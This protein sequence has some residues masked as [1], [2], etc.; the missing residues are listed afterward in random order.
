MLVTRPY[1]L[2]KILTTVFRFIYFFRK[3]DSQLHDVFNV[4]IA[5]EVR[6]N[7][8]MMVFEWL[9]VFKAEWYWM[10]I[11]S[12]ISMIDQGFTEITIKD[13]PSTNYEI[14]TRKLPYNQIFNLTILAENRKTQS[15]PL[16]I[17]FL[18]SPPPIDNLTIVTSHEKA[19]A[20]WI[21]EDGAEW[22]ELKF[23][24]KDNKMI[25]E[26]DVPLVEESRLTERY[27]EFDVKPVEGYVLQIRSLAYD[28]YGNV[29][30]GEWLTVQFYSEFPPLTKL[31]K[32]EDASD[33]DHVTYSWN[34]VGYDAKY[35]LQLLDLDNMA[36]VGVFET[37]Q[38]FYKI[39]GLE[40]ARKY[41][42]QVWPINENTRGDDLTEDFIT[43]LCMPHDVFSPH[44]EDSALEIEW[45]PINLAQKYSVHVKPGPSNGNQLRELKES[46]CYIETL[47]PGIQ[48]T[49]SVTAKMTRS[50]GVKVQSR[51]AKLYQYTKLLAPK[52]LCINNQLLHNSS[53]VFTWAEMGGAEYY[54]MILKECTPPPKHIL[55]PGFSMIKGQRCPKWKADNLKC[56]K[57]GVSW[58]SSSKYLMR[59]ITAGTPELGPKA[60]ILSDTNSQS[61][62][63]LLPGNIYKLWL[64]GV[65]KQT[66]SEYGVTHFVTR[67]KTTSDVTFDSLTH[68]SVHFKWQP[69][70]QAQ[71]YTIVVQTDDKK[72]KRV[73]KISVEGL[74]TTVKKLHPN[75]AYLFEVIGENKISFSWPFPVTLR[76]LL[77][78]TTILSPYDVPRGE[79]VSSD[80]FIIKW[81]QVEGAEYYIVNITGPEDF[82]KT[83]KIK[84]KTL[85]EHVYQPTGLRHNA[86]HDI[87]I[88]A[89]NK[90]TEG[91]LMTRSFYTRPSTPNNFRGISVYDDEVTVGWDPV[92][93]ITKYDIHVYDEDK[94]INHVVIEDGTQHRFREL[95]PNHLYIFVIRAYGN[96]VSDPATIKIYTKIQGVD[97]LAMNEVYDD[98]MVLD[99]KDADGALEYRVEFSYTDATGAA[100][101]MRIEYSKYS[102]CELKDLVPNSIYYIEIFGVNENTVGMPMN[103]TVITKLGYIKQLRQDIELSSDTE[104]MIKWLQVP[105]ADFFTIKVT[106]S[107]N[108]KRIQSH[109]I[110]ATEESILL[111]GLRPQT[112]YDVEIQAFS[113][114]S[115][116]YPTSF[117]AQTSKSDGGF[118]FTTTSTTTSTTLQPLTPI[119][120]S[121]FIITTTT[122]TTTTTTTSS[123]T[124]TSIIIVERL[125]PRLFPDEIV[126]SKIE[127]L[128]A[129][130]DLPDETQAAILGPVREA[131]RFA[132]ELEVDMKKTGSA[133]GVQAK[134]NK[135]AKLIDKKGF[136]LVEYNVLMEVFDSLSMRPHGKTLL[137]SAFI[138]GNLK[139]VE[140]QDAAV[141]LN[142]YKDKYDLSDQSVLAIK[143]AMTM[144]LPASYHSKMS[145]LI[146]DS[147]GSLSSPQLRS[148]FYDV[149]NIL[150]SDFKLDLYDKL[151]NL[152]NLDETKAQF[153][154][155][156][157]REIILGQAP[158]PF[159]PPK[160]YKTITSLE[161]IKKISLNGP[162][163]V[164]LVQ[165][166]LPPGQ[167]NQMIESILNVDSNG[168]NERLKGFIK[169]NLDKFLITDYMEHFTEMLDQFILPPL[170]RK[171]IFWLIDSQ[172]S[173]STEIISKTA[174]DYCEKL[175]KKDVVFS[176][177]KQLFEK[178]SESEIADF[179]FSLQL[180][181]ED[182]SNRKFVNAVQA[183]KPNIETVEIFEKLISMLDIRI[184][185]HSTGNHN[186]DTE[187]N[188]IFFDIFETV[189]FEKNDVKVN[190]D[191]K[192][193]ENPKK[194]FP[195]IE[196]DDFEE[197]VS[198]MSMASPK[199]S[200]F[201]LGQL[202]D[203]S[204]Q[205][206]KLRKLEPSLVS[207][208]K[209]TVLHLAKTIAPK[210]FGTIE[211]LFNRVESGETIPTPTIG[212]FFE[213][214]KLFSNGTDPLVN[215][216]TS[217]SPEP[218]PKP[219]PIVDEDIGFDIQFYTRVPPIHRNNTYYNGNNLLF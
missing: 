29:T 34:D 121:L 202:L 37:D 99:W 136:S 132:L 6:H 115:D 84:P 165:R 95:E 173:Q 85:E 1:W 216:V 140:K 87:T 13:I 52:Q 190:F 187:Q 188:K 48:Y 167:I 131:A 33:C 31:E 89:F 175:P 178:V 197:L 69:I 78:P 75:F 88:E 55:R 80:G 118:I 82:L 114:I 211:K 4:T 5:E 28:Y 163:V 44:Q 125:L 217:L 105:N 166:L 111:V 142:N 7:E 71:K 184:S 91:S 180:V 61:F 146:L 70:D 83:Q 198:L 123:A 19:S 35:K 160:V 113:S 58:D 207:K 64:G 139:K 39:E 14:D 21:T 98:R 96:I 209:N 150:S 174:K 124:S 186:S 63:K 9:P 23:F 45:S 145:F 200:N 206:L 67:L 41:S 215:F 27:I 56:Q 18:T 214:A 102:N 66:Y 53:A 77:A 127:N 129:D 10:R 107:R 101:D 195:M 11:D 62:E 128:F 12:M 73:Q 97:Y 133:S 151:I 15:E 46:Q 210:N 168:S 47:T 51:T 193:L 148:V 169:N 94:H 106:N 108:N 183:M 122:S 109:K 92:D 43:L 218:L 16:I 162:D 204:L 137:K 93:E 134:L 24:N 54:Y 199:I 25:E 49:I 26:T 149:K 20:E 164:T 179:I 158:E 60:F 185:P 81:S 65:N 32:D 42:L 3:W 119:P 130:F 189:F 2:F 181:N 153:A 155:G 194:M 103:L 79:E 138:D 126:A 196:T 135:I 17:E 40:N 76:T 36:S 100:S 157:A 208:F 110:D 86:K 8:T 177:A 112:Q 176:L 205:K 152:F 120:K 219:V 192:I 203:K 159:I 90:W 38:T 201:K 50:D 117:K 170:K 182:L 212:N 74:E 172:M 213:T 30:E 154:R 104:M 156:L 171:Y 22:F 72:R 59:N 57:M 161:D 116:S 191:E 143:N 144:F 147:W 68:E 141:V